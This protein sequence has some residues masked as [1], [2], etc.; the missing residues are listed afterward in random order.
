MTKNG[1]ISRFYGC[2]GKI[3]ASAG[4]SEQRASFGK[5]IKFLKF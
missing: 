3:W 4:I 2:P 1:K 5:V